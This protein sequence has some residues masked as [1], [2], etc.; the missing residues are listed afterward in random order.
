MQES[1][2][3]PTPKRFKPA[4]DVRSA[5]FLPGKPVFITR[6]KSRGKFA[7]G[8][9]YERK[10]HE[11]LAL[12]ALGVPGLNYVE[13]PWIEFEDASGTRYCQLDGLLLDKTNR[14]A[15]IYEVKY[16]H[17]ANAWWQLTQLYEPVVRVLLPTYRP[18]CLMEIV[19]WHDPQVTF[20]QRYDLTSSPLKVPHANKVAVCIFNPRTHRGI[21]SDGCHER[22]SVREAAGAER[23]A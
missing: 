12:L 4:I 9:R 15:L 3:L 21:Q 19:H 18:I 17:I 6:K 20:P 23:N 16:K 22:E 5:K 1:A 13:S 11:H 2:P 7:V 14:S 8:I 10:V